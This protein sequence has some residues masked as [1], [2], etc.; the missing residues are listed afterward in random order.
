[1]KFDVLPLQETYHLI[2]I[3]LLFQIAVDLLGLLV[4]SVLSKK[5]LSRSKKRIF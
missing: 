1:M 2:Y 5:F 4:T 3:I